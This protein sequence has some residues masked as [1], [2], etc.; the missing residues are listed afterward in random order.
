MAETYDDP[1]IQRQFDR[2]GPAYRWLVTMSGLTGA[3]SMILSATIVNVAVPS[4]MGAY[5]IGQ[6][7]AQW[8]AT[9]F[10]STMVAS[11]LLN[12]WVVRALGQRLAYSLTLI[13]FVAGAFVCAFSPNMDV[14]IIG[15]IMQGFSAG[16]IQPL[17]LATMVAVFPKN[18]RGF[19]V[20]MYG[21]G[22][23]LAPSFGPLVGGLTI[24]F[25]TWRHA[26]IMPLPLVLIAFVGGLIFMPAKKFERR[27]PPFN[28]PG[29]I[30]LCVSLVLVMRAIG[31]GQRWGWTSDLTM[32]TAIGGVTAFALFIYSQ[33][34]TK[35]PLLD[36]TLFLDPKFAAAMAI[37]FAFGAGNFATNYAIPV[38]VQTIQHFTPTQSGL[39]LVPA[40]LFLFT[41]IP[42]SGRI[43]DS[44]PPHIPITA[45]C[46][47]FATATFLISSS[48][49]NTAF[50]TMAGLTVMS[51]AALGLVMPNLGGAAMRSIT[52][53][54]LNAAAG[55]YNF[56]RQT[57]GAFGVNITAAL[58]EY[59]SAHHADWLTATQTSGNDFTREMLEQVRRLLAEGGL[60]NLALE[61]GAYDYLSRTI[62]AQ[63]RTFGFQ[64][65]FLI[66]SAAFIIALIPAMM[67]A[68]SSRK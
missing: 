57:G 15:R 12:S 24:D 7:V 2:Y 27:L 38:F 21:L 59:R 49:V 16:I 62:Y 4:I 37:G 42:I 13:I 18:R 58:I 14:L 39:V 45:G 53:E 52:A 30:L 35:S 40:G 10:L 33:L 23:T 28:W 50:W 3:I 26:F 8:A 60:S 55:A 64:D 63:A 48:D 51:R 29:F 46:I 68:R 22:V 36:P 1:A 34:K 32:M 56:I 54:K 25:L 61:W 66:I 41:L 20:G 5:G 19:A 17:V 9:A 31:N 6:D 47:I 43:A 65:T 11:Q 67:L 44:V